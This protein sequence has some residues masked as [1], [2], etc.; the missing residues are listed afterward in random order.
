MGIFIKLSQ[1]SQTKKHLMNVEIVHLLIDIVMSSCIEEFQNNGN[2]EE[3]S[4]AKDALIILY[5]LANLNKSKFYIP[6]ETIRQVEDRRKFIIWGGFL[7]LHYI[8]NKSKVKEVIDFWDNVK[9]KYLDL[10][11]HEEVVKV[12]RSY[13]KV[14]SETKLKEEN[15]MTERKMEDD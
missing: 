12:I 8:S 15:N 10:R 4:F 5:N 3:Q 9:L 7:A 13:L 2:F 14:T 11:D 1:D 6:G